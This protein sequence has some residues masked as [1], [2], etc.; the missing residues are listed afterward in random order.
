[1]CKSHLH[2]SLKKKQVVKNKSANILRGPTGAT[3]DVYVKRP[4]IA[5]KAHCH[6]VKA[7]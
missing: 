4:V 2:S 5:F 7:Q 1:M 3:L 6:S